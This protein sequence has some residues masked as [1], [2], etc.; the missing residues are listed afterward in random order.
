MTH[1]AYPQ[2]RDGEWLRR[3]YNDEVATLR[4]IAGEVGCTPTTVQQWL[5]RH[6]IPTRSS[7]P[8]PRLSPGER[9]WRLVVIDA[10]GEAQGP[11]NKR[12]YRALCDCGNETIVV[13]SELRRGKVR[14]CGCLRSTHGHTR[15]RSRTYTSWVKMTERCTSPSCP[16]WPDYGGRGITIAPEWAGPGGFAQFLADMGERPEDKTIDRIDNDGNY[17][18]RNCR[19]ATASEQAYNRRPKRKK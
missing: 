18:P 13:G 17:E 4:Q 11:D 6:G 14:S 10:T 5:V 8:R 19:W 3:R 16:A 15:P 9:Y 7:A 2:L 12:T 1:L